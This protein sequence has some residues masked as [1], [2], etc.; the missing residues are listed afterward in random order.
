LLLDSVRAEHCPSLSVVFLV[1]PQLTTVRLDHSS[2][3]SLLLDSNLLQGELDLSTLPLL[4]SLTVRAPRLSK[5]VLAPRLTYLEDLTLQLESLHSLMWSFTPDSV[6]DSISNIDLSLGIES[7]SAQLSPRARLQTFAITN[8]TNL[9]SLQLNNIQSKQL[10]LA[11]LPRL[12]QLRLVACFGVSLPEHYNGERFD[13][14]QVQVTFERC[15][16]E[17]QL[18]SLLVSEVSET[19]EK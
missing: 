19:T 3:Q 10:R 11:A 12:E 7:F 5:L 17:S 14:R 9:K 13:E 1:A 8:C 4:T 15:S 2:I 18:R 6:P 16:F